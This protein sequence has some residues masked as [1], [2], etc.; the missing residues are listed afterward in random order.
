M[1]GCLEK[2]AA[3][4]PLQTMSTIAGGN[5]T[6]CSLKQFQKVEQEESYLSHQGLSCHKRFQHDKFIKIRPIFGKMLQTQSFYH[7]L[8]EKFN[9]V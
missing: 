1:R 6:K 8:L 3:G 9:A 2:R 4:T 5:G 7:F